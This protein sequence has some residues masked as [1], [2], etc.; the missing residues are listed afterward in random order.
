[1]AVVLRKLRITKVDLCKSGANPDADIKIFKSADPV[2][3]RNIPAS[4]R[5][6]MP[7]SNFAGPHE[8]FPIEEPGDVT[9]A[10]DLAGHA[11]NPDA[12]RRHIISIARRKGPE[13]VARLPKTANVSK[14]DTSVPKPNKID[15]TKATPEQMTAYAQELEK[16]LEAQE[17]HEVEK[18]KKP[19]T[20]PADADG[21]ENDVEK[22]QNCDV[23]MKKSLTTL[24]KQVK[25]QE[26]E[27][28]KAKDEAA[29]AREEVRKAKD[30]AEL[31]KIE[32]QV[33][34]EMP[35]IPG[36]TLEVA[37]ML[38]QAKATLTAEA[39]S[40]LEK[41]LKAGSEAIAK[42]SQEIGG[43]SS[44]P[45]GSAEQEIIKSADDLVSQG[46]FKTRPE[47][48]THITKSNP[49][50]AERYRLEKHPVRK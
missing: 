46:K 23:A 42:A 11:D 47:A 28:K 38:Q 15:L 34:A 43:G 12:V 13:F 14:E 44:Q 48:I 31:V 30:E 24:E 6:Q 17:Q 27:I 10:W 19:K 35:K 9:D 1:M 39:Y 2:A 7:R 37:K 18:A 32:K 3:K 40:T 33:A 50:L 22:N 29:A 26:A 8:S 45:V 16:A 21:D 4:H 25:E 5:H 36:T 41:A 49:D 20:P